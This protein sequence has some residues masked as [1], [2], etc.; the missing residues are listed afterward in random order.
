MVNPALQDLP[1]HQ[2]H[3]APLVNQDL[4]GHKDPQVLVFQDHLEELVPEDLLAHPDSPVCSPF[5]FFYSLQFS[6]IVYP[7]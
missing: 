7:C 3:P 2:D 4:L 1:D 5:V 6:F